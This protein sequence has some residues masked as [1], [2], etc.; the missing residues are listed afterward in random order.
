MFDCSAFRVQ[1]GEN[2]SK[3]CH[4]C[5]RMTLNLVDDSLKSE[6]DWIAVDDKL[7]SI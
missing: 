7:A 4:E 6:K 2:E 3:E 1:G 5:Q